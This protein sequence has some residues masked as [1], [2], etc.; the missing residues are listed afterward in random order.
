MASVFFTPTGSAE[1]AS[2]SFDGNTDVSVKNLTQGSI[3]L[4]VQYPGSSRWDVVMQFT[5]PKNYDMIMVAGDSTAL[6]RF[7]SLD[8]NAGVEC[9]MG[10]N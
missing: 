1:S 5:A 8:V 7:R 4:E 3:L 2:A 9:Y 10:D 6:Y